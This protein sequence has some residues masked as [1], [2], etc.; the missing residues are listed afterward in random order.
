MTVQCA[1]HARGRGTAVGGAGQAGRGSRRVWACLALVALVLGGAGTAAVRAASTSP[2]L[3]ALAPSSIRARGLARMIGQT[4]PDVDVRAFRHFA[5]L[6]RALRTP[7]SGAVMAL[8]PSLQALGANPVLQGTL[9]GQATQQYLVVSRRPMTHQDL[10][11]A[12][13]GVVDLVGRKRLPGF[14]SS[15]LLLE[16]PPKIRRVTRADDLLSVLALGMADCVL[17]PE[18]ELT[19]LNRVAQLEVYTLRLDSA[20]VGYTA[21]AELGPFQSNILTRLERLSKKVLKVLGIDAWR[22][23]ATP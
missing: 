19:A 8:A 10:A 1:E 17:L 20:R 22:A 3:Y 13:I 5:D 12:R 4:D 14:V 16:R 18:Q 7:S 15:I 11:T 6:E 23:G 21:I 9:R 2:V